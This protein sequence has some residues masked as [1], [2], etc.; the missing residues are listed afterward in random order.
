MV[1]GTCL[2]AYLASGQS[3]PGNDTTANVHQ[4]VQL[5]DHGSLFFTPEQNPK[6]FMFSADTPG[7][8]KTN[9]IRD[10][11]AFTYQGKPAR[12]AYQQGLLRVDDWL[13]YVVPTRHAGKYA[14]TFGLGAGLFAAPLMIP[15]RLVVRDLATKVDL[16]WWLAKL[17]AALSVAGTALVLYLAARR[18]FSARVAVLVA[19]AYGLGTCAYSVSSQA[20]WQHGPCELFLALGAYFLLAKDGRRSDLLCGLCFAAATVCR[21]TAILVVSCV[22]LHH[23]LFDRRRLPWYLLGGLPLAVALVTY[24]LWAFGS[25][26]TVGQLRVAEVVARDKTGQTGVWQTPLW[27]GLAGLLVSPSRGLFVYSPLA[28]LACW[29]AGRAFRNPAWRELRPLA[30]AAVL[31]VVVAAKRFDWWGGW[32]FGYRPIVDVAILLAFLAFPVIESISASRSWQAVFGVLFA[33][34]F[35]VQVLG[36]FVYDVAGWNGRTVWDVTPP[37]TATP[38]TFHDAATAARYV[39][40][41]GGKAQPRELN[42]DFP[43]GR[44]RLWSLTD[45]PLV[46]YLGNLSES[47]EL[48]RRA[49]TEFL[50]DD[51]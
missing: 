14:N 37:G 47:V 16:L 51:G 7:G 2:V 3:Q 4:A 35:A 8:K 28:L 18:H 12:E 40:E 49:T 33:Y 26:F 39:R 23:L 15:V 45:S 29:G 22:G 46:Y 41:R 19:L 48:R 50:H 21:P 20:L 6:M 31:L 44:W 5:V 17:A 25:P 42:V 1:F 32:C 38:V 36:A 24:S 9:R 34:S 30:L 10:W 43:E 27:Q 13:Y 11:N